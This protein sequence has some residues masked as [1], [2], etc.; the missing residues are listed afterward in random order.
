MDGSLPPREGGAGAPDAASPG[1]DG[2]DAGQTVTTVTCA[3]LPPLASGIC[4]VTT[5]SA[6][7]LLEG[8]VLAPSTVYVGGQV[9]IDGT[10]QIT[11]VGCDC[12]AGGE[13]T[14]VCP[15]AI[16]SP[17]LINTHDHIT[18]TQ[19]APY[20]DTGVRYEDRQQWRE[21]LDGKAKI[22]APGGASADQVSW[23][24]LRF[25]MGGATSTVGSGGEAGLL[26]NLDK[27]TLEEGLN[28]PAVDFDTFPLDD[29]SGTRRTGDCNYGGTAATAASVASYGAFEPHVS[30][31]I[32]VTARN[33]FLC[34]SSASYDVTAPGVSN[35]LLLPKTAMIH[36]VGLEPADYGQMAVAGTSLIWS[37]RSNITLYGDTARVTVAARAGVTIALGTDWLPSGSM[38]MLRELACADS[39]N[40]TYL[41]GFFSDLQLWRMVTSSAAAVVHM[42]DALG[43]LAPGKVAD[44]SIFAANG[45]ATP[46]RSILEA[47]PA[48]VALVLRGGKAL[49]GEDTTVNALATSCDAVSVC[50]ANKAVCLT[51]EINLTYSALQA[52]VGTDYPAFACGTPTNEPSCTPMRP[53]SVAGSTCLYAGRQPSATDADGDGIPDGSDNCPS[54]FNPVR[55]LDEGKQGDADGDG[56]GDACDPCPLDAGT[57]TC[58]AVSADDS[59]GDGVANETD[60]CPYVPNPDQ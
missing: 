7:K 52:A 30:E 38:N 8:T 44:V 32:D 5:G 47:Q 26:R 39:F 60:N 37:P 29:S 19:D 4:V 46:Y 34:E 48:D 54:I 45:K 55:P 36:G 14:I 17:G 33:E 12:A 23:G 22:P 28:E 1:A 9:A 13:T 41:G 57:T 20:E 31:G 18:Y 56:V 27:A 59:D 49:Y 43:S 50:G 40:Q 6:V 51:E 58:T 21:G 15:G 3:T 25:V 42:D 24:E 16:I 35:D 53:T 10:G 2:G 11:C